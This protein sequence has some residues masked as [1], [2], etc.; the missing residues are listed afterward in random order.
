[1]SVHKVNVAGSGQMAGNTL[2]IRLDLMPW[3]KRVGA[4]V[5]PTELLA[6]DSSFIIALE[7]LIYLP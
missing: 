6:V 7:I 2:Q 4:N 3:E 5:L 1:M